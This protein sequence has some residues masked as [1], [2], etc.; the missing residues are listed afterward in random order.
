MTSFSR[1][2]ISEQ[3]V[4]L[5]FGNAISVE[6]HQQVLRYASAIQQAHMP[7]FVEC[8]P[9]YSTLTIHFDLFVVH[10]SNLIGQ[11]PLEKVFNYIKSLRIESIE[12]KQQKKTHEIPVCYDD[13]FGLDLNELSGSLNL[14]ASHLVSHTWV[15]SIR[16]W[17]AVEKRTHVK[18]C[19]LVRWPLP[20]NKRASI[21]L[22][23]RAAG[24]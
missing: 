4:T 1:Y 9:A 17:S 6:I 23:L 7:G 8:V 2:P 16:D 3:A 20:E 24:K 13:D 22:I 10:R 14:S 19:Q 5:Q 12:K 18:K 15:K 21:H 11:T